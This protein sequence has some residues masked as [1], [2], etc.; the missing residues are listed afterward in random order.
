MSADFFSNNPI[1]LRQKVEKYV[2]SANNK[3]IV[4]GTFEKNMV[5]S[6]YHDHQ[7]YYK[8][9][10]SVERKS[11]NKDFIHVLISEKNLAK[12]NMVSTTSIKGRHAEIL[13]TFDS[14][15]EYDQQ[16]KLH[17]KL[18][19]SA[20]KINLNADIQEV[21]TNIIYLN[22]AICKPPIFRTTSLGKNVTECMISVR[23][24]NGSKDY[25]PCICWKN[26]A[27]NISKLSVKDQIELYGRI[28]SRKYFK[29]LSETETIEKEVYEISILFFRI[30]R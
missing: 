16:N 11:G 28:Q 1:I 20:K 26:V 12:C 6:H 23:R 17:L 14:Y 21:D 22:G 19:I 8:T 18:Y 27:Y 3:V 7:S 5:Y 13:G 25:I 24:K 10:I 9:I 4:S 2:F 15:D 29:K 30:V